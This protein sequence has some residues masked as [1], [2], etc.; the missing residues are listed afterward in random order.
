MKNQIILTALITV[1]SICS[2]A[3]ASEYA[4]VTFS[5]SVIKLPKVKN[6]CLV[7]KDTPGES[8]L[9]K[10]MAEIQLTANNKL[11]Q[12]WLDCPDLQILKQDG[13]V[14][15]IKSWV[16]VFATMAKGKELLFP[17]STGQQWKD[18][19]VSLDLG[20][21]SFESRVNKALDSSGL[22]N[23]SIDGITDLGVLSID[24][25]IHKGLFTL[26]NQEPVVGIMSSN[27][28]RGAPL[29]IA[30]YSHEPSP[31][32]IISLLNKAKQHTDLVTFLNE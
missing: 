2:N 10:K 5:T 15:N 20:S 18:A 6:F 24:N 29:T 7:T 19:L 13:Y 17:E 8:S 30:T 26:V 11:F 23:D 9:F 32:L 1:F 12:I 16:L 3:H 22:G 4:T 27:V 14:S 21:E 31:E 28:V 25:F